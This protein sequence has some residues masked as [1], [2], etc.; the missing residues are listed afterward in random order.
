[1]VYYGARPGT[2][3]AAAVCCGYLRFFTTRTTAEQWTGQQADLRGAVLGQTEA[4]RRAQT[5]SASC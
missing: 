4:E 5:S 3:P 1:M 2:G